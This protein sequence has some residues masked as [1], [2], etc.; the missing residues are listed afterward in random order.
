M[1]IGS[2]R[3]RA[4]DAQAGGVII[5]PANVDGRSEW[6]SPTDCA[7]IALNPCRLNDLGVQ[8]FDAGCVELRPPPFGAV[9]LK[10]LHVAELIKM[11]LAHGDAASAIYID[12][13]ITLMGI[14]LLRNYSSIERSAGRAKGG[15]SVWA[16]RRVRE[17]LEEN[18]TRKLAVMELAAIS[19]L[20][21]GRFIPAFTRTF[22]QTPHQYVINLRLNFAE[23]LLLDGNLK[24]S[25]IA[26]L[27][28]FSSQSH[29]TALLRNSKGITPA[30]IRQRRQ[31]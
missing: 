10:A 16:G 11:E 15:L 3:M 20:S 8:E 13:L 2:D 26:Y 31:A 5:Q 9:D 21:P 24:I 18:F 23:A 7:L 14:H 4:F 1:A 6:K 28:G 22:G 29:L 30:Q 12:S 17:Y 27:S 19:G 25:E